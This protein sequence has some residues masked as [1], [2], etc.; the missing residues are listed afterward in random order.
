MFDS[1]SLVAWLMQSCLRLSNSNIHDGFS[2]SFYKNAMGAV[3]VFGAC[4]KILAKL[5]DYV[6]VVDNQIDDPKKNSHVP[7]V[8]FEGATVITYAPRSYNC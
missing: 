2:E 6:A 4:L 1:F 8:C 7:P 3:S 5:T